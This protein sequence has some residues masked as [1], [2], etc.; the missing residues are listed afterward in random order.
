MISDLACPI[1]LVLCYKR[2]HGIE[3][4]A[5]VKP[6]CHQVSESFDE[7]SGQQAH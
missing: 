3:K 7:W 2:I 5:F 1:K 6:I 4:T